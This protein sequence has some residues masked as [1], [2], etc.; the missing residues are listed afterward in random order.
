MD[1]DLLDILKKCNIIIEDN[2]L[3]SG[4]IIPREILLSKEKFIEL[5]DEIK[6]MKGLSGRKFRK[7]S[8]LMCHNCKKGTN[9]CKSQKN[10]KLYPNLKSPDYMFLGDDQIRKKL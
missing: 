7:D 10:K 5:S 8:V 1:K 4:L 6:T 2:N 3:I 9:C